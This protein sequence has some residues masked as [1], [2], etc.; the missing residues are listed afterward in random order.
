MIE[1]YELNHFAVSI[2]NFAYFFSFLT[3]Q[4]AFAHQ[5]HEVLMGLQKIFK[6]FYLGNFQLYSGPLSRRIKAKRLYKYLAIGVW[7]CKNG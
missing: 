1:I 6:G 5:H 2:E 7:L 4:V 3:R